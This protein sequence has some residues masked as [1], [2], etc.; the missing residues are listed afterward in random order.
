M[1]KGK[2]QRR[3]DVTESVRHRRQRGGVI[4]R[5]IIVALQTCGNRQHIKQP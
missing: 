2:G 4:T 3:L 5:D 1:V